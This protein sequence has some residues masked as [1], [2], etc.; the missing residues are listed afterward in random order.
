M[1]WAEAHLSGAVPGPEADYPGRVT[2]DLRSDT[3]TQPTPAMREAIAGAQVGDD[4]F[5]EDPTVNRLQERCA[6]LAGKEAALLMPSGT[7]ANLVAC[8]SHT[9]P[10]DEVIVEQTSHLYRYEAGGFAAVAGVSVAL[11]PGERGM[12]NSE[13]VGP[14]VRASDAH[15]PR[16]RLLWLENTHNVGG[17]TC[18]ALNALEAL[19]ETARSRGLRVHIDGARI[20]NACAARGYSLA[21]A[22][23]AA[24][25]ASF[26][27]SKG[28]G[29]PAGS[30]LVG[31]GEFIAT[32][33]RVRK[34]LGG[35]MR[36]AGVLAAAAEYALDHHIDRLVVDHDHARQLAA[37][38]AALPG[39]QV[40]TP[41]TNIV[42]LDII[43]EHAD[44]PALAERLRQA[45][46]RVLPVGPKRLRLVTHLDVSSGDIDAA[47]IIL[48]HTLSRA[49]LG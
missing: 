34:M 12:L 14:A 35:G 41:Q 43:D 39:Y 37:A 29:C 20:W 21:Q 11:L 26:C 42:M 1:M 45:G 23:A 30:M 31:S 40:Q 9:A 5:G 36:Q 6:A 19:G 46:L 49:D 22:L 10:G 25:S 8:R 18:Y 32:A 17:G 13:Q 15:Y 16:T 4:V 33:R 44:A 48:Q 24:D 47:C 27:F 2:I 7:M 3:L 38:I 28:L